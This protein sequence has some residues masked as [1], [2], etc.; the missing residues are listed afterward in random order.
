MAYLRLALITI[1][2]SVIAKRKR[3]TQCSVAVAEF[4]GTGGVNG[5]IEI[6]EDGRVN[7][8]LNIAGLDASQCEDGGQEFAYHIHELWEYDDLTPRFGSDACGPTY[9]GGMYN[10]YNTFALIAVQSS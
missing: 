7:V 4:D 2:T 6:D 3:T 10:M 9:T 8:D 1:V 5:Q